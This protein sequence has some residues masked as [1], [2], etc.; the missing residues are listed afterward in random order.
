MTIRPVYPL[1]SERLRLEPFQE[2]DI[3]ELY[4]MERDPEVKRYGGGVLTR[5]QA[6]KLLKRFVAQ[7]R[8]TGWGAVAIKERAT[9]RIVGLCGIYE[10]E[11]LQEAE[12]F[13]GLARD[14]WGQ[15][16]ATEAAKA[17]VFAALREWG[18]SRIVVPVNPENVRSIR[19]LEK[20]GMRFSHAVNDPE[21]GGSVHVYD[22]KAEMP[23]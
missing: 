13:Y 1:E 18:V 5:A 3:N 12:L 23:R 2:S 16:Y 14:A 7:V 6:E 11:N 22:L 15:G 21:S 10:T 17:L 9:G 4:V 8:D 20:I 19:V